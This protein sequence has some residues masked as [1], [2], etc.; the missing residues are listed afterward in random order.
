MARRGELRLFIHEHAR[1]CDSSSSTEALHRAAHR[2]H[3][4]GPTQSATGAGRRQDA[5]ACD[6]QFF[7]QQEQFRQE[8]RSQSRTTTARRSTGASD[9]DSDSART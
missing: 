6:V 3:G 7:Y 8:V 5:G 2:D 4:R 1:P 9:S